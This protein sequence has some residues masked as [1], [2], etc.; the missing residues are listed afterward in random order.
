[1]PDTHFAKFTEAT[2]QLLKTLKGIPANFDDSLLTEY[3]QLVY[4]TLTALSSSQRFYVPN[5]ANT[6]DKDTLDKTAI[7]LPYP[8]IAILDEVDLFDDVT[9]LDTKCGSAWKISIGFT[10][11]SELNYKFKLLNDYDPFFGVLSIVEVNNQWTCTPGVISCTFREGYRL[12]AA[13]LECSRVFATRIGKDFSI[14][15]EFTQ[16][17][18]S[19]VN[20]CTMLSLHNVKTRTV[21]PPEK[22]QKKRLKH[23]GKPLFSYKVLVVDGEEWHDSGNRGTGTGSVRSHMRRGHIRQL[24]NSDRRVWVRATLVHGKAA[25]FVSKDYKLGV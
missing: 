18:Y 17:V 23:G 15:R 6:I 16:D 4:A 8:C 24:H 22:L 12:L 20:L 5:G 1:M 14:E 2:N 10:A 11:D 3:G 25:G 9:N 7:Q 13:D 21:A 19:I